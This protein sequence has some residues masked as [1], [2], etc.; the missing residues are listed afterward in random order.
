MQGPGMLGIVGRRRFI[1]TALQRN[2]KSVVCLHESAKISR[3]SR[4]V[5]QA[6]ARGA[7]VG[8]TEEVRWISDVVRAV[9][10]DTVHNCFCTPY[11]RVAAGG[12]KSL[13]IRMAAATETRNFRGA[14]RSIKTRV[15]G[16]ERERLGITTVTA[17]TTDRSYRVDAPSS[18]GYRF[19]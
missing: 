3:Q 19:G 14:E 10:I 16:F 13:L 4:K 12:V 1:E 7:I 17:G 15:G 11:S 9:T 5:F 6:V 8:E 2:R 18:A